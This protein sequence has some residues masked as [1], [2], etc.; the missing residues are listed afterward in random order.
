MKTQNIFETNKNLF[1]IGLILLILIIIGTSL[2]FCGFFTTVASWD[3]GRISGR[4]LRLALKDTYGTDRKKHA[5]YSE[6]YAFATELAEKK[7]L[8]QVARKKGYENDMWYTYK[9]HELYRR[10]GIDLWQRM[11]TEY[12]PTVTQKARNSYYTMYHLRRIVI[13]TP[14]TLSKREIKQKMELAQSLLKRIKAGEDI[15]QLANEYTDDPGNFHNGWRGEVNA[16]QLQNILAPE[17]APIAQRLE[18]GEFSDP[19]LL[20]DGYHIIARNPGRDINRYSMCRIL[21]TYN[22]TLS[23]EKKNTQLKKLQEVTNKLRKGENPGKLANLYSDDAANFGRGMIHLRGLDFPSQKLEHIVE[24]LKP[25]EVTSIIKTPDS[26]QIIKLDSRETRKPNT[27]QEMMIAIENQQIIDGLRRYATNKIRKKLDRRAKIVTGAKFYFDTYEPNMDDNAVL[28]AFK[29]SGTNLTFS[30]LKQQMSKFYRDINQANNFMHNEF[31]RPTMYFLAARKSG[32]L[33]TASARRILQRKYQDLLIDLLH[34]TIPGYDISR[35]TDSDVHCYYEQLQLLDPSFAVNPQNLNSL[36]IQYHAKK[37]REFMKSEYNKIKKEHNYTFRPQGVAFIARKDGSVAFHL[38]Q[39]ASARGQ[40][41]KARS[42][43]KKAIRKD[44]N[45]AA[46]YIALALLYTEND[47]LTEPRLKKD[48]GTPFDSINCAQH[49]FTELQKVKKLRMDDLD[50][51]INSEQAVHNADAMVN[52]LRSLQYLYGSGTTALSKLLIEFIYT[53]DNSMLQ[54]ECFTA[55]GHL[56]DS[57]G[58]HALNQ[59]LDIA[60]GVKSSALFTD[61]TQEETTVWLTA[62]IPALAQYQKDETAQLYISI[63]NAMDLTSQ[64]N[65]NVNFSVFYIEALGTMHAKSAVPTLDKIYNNKRVLVGIRYY[66]A[67]ALNT[68]LNTDTYVPPDFPG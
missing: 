37:N 27:N 1:R 25:G 62:L 48:D 52:I 61:I 64:N 8:A 17:L 12:S 5:S 44:R 36:R 58:F 13:N 18:M 19:I 38:A 53:T 32:Q 57:I 65:W 54:S 34:G 11:L 51:F 29:R 4:E 23:D 50:S 67:Q 43:L 15:G 26:L 41:Q 40:I 39:E 33:S 9:S 42:L 47:N 55:L 45:Y 6:L 10:F 2:Y 3:N 49:Y 30:D 28:V 63:I 56:K 24:K 22:D 14:K 7:L 20:T 31:Y 66:A 35:V 46:A 60:R 59:F 21:I 16:Q 68:I